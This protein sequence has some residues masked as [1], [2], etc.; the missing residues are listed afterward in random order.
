MATSKKQWKKAE[1]EELPLPSGNTC[2][3]KRPGME[4]IL[5]AGVL[6]D[7]MT[8]MALD[9]VKTAQTGKPQ[10]HKSKGG[11][12]DIDPEM[13]EKFM[14]EENA[15]ENIF[16]AFDR[17]TAMC[18]IEPK[19]LWHLRPK[20]N[21]DGSDVLDDSGKPIYEE[22]PEKERD[23]DILYTDEIDIDDKTFIF[24]FVVGGT[25]DVE[26]FRLQ[27]GDAMATVQP[28]EDVELPTK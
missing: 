10:D 18:V 15:I 21:E 17:V 23:E 22:I 24:N 13:M 28:S 26:Q 11:D 27:Y 2:M 16:R 19:C 20:I 3:V 4:K 9:Y 25:R 6:P 8:S 5:G 14:K 7:N 1:G 12:P